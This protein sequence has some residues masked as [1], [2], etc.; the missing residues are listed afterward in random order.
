MIERGTGFF[1]CGVIDCYRD[2]KLNSASIVAL[3]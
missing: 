3:G 2:A 1:A